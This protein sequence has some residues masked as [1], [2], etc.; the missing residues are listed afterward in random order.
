MAVIDVRSS[1]VSVPIRS[2][3]CSRRRRTVLST[4]AWPASVK[5]PLRLLDGD[6][7][8]REMMLAI[9]SSAVDRALAAAR[10]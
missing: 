1:D 10:R 2:V 4:R 7:P 5:R 9:A 8:E 3:S 6:Y